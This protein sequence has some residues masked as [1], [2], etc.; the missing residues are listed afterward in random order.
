MFGRE[1]KSQSIEVTQYE[2][3]RLISITSAIPLLGHATGGVTFESVGD[4][5][6]LSRWSEL[7]LGRANGLLGPILARVLRSS[8]EADLRRAVPFGSPLATKE[9]VPP[10]KLRRIR[11]VDARGLRVYDM[12]GRHCGNSR[13]ERHEVMTGTAMPVGRWLIKRSRIE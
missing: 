6:R 13:R 2:P 5:T 9:E 4:D 11:S 10:R 8:P 12:A 7:E 3:G 1:I